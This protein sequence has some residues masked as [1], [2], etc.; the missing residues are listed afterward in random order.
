MVQLGDYVELVTGFPFKSAEYS[1]D[2]SG[3]RLLRGDN[4]VQRSIRW[5]GVKYWPTEGAADK[6]AFSLQHGDVVLAMDRPWIEAGL[7][8]AAV[9]SSDIPA[10]LVQRVARLRAERGLD[11]NFLSYVMF[12]QAFSDYVR[13]IQTGTAVPHISGPQIRSFMFPLPPVSEQR[14]IAATLGTL[15]DLVEVN[16]SLAKSC[17]ELRKCEGAALVKRASSTNKLSSLARFVNGKNFTNKASGAGRPVIRTPELRQGPL[18]STVRS[19]LNAAK[20][21]IAE[22]GDVLFVWSGT[23]MV[24]RWVYEEGL[25]NQHIFKVIPEA[26]VP[27]WLVMSLIELQMPWFVG[28]AAD[29]ATTMGHIQRAH[30]DALVPVPSQEELLAAEH[31]IGPLWDAE[32]DLLRE[33]LLLEATRDELLPLLMSGRATLGEVAA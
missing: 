20:D 17:R 21:N 1:S 16:R 12:S 5:A 25:I 24:D 31:V 7:K 22:P 30:L 32:L 2:A 11:Q 15:D 4:V 9:R 18:G 28:L 33:A 26:G 29:K 10:L 3:I 23:L 8:V 13:A 27:A 6:A 14:R 19:N